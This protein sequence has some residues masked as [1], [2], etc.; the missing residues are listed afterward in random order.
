MAWLEAAKRDTFSPET[1]EVWF[2]E[3]NRLGWTEDVFRERVL[4]TVRSTTFGKV[5]FDDFIGAEKLF[6]ESEKNELVDRIIENRRQTFI[7]AGHSEDDCAEAG[8]IDVQSWWNSK[9]NRR[10]EEIANKIDEHC[11]DLRSK[12]TL[13]PFE[14][15]QVLL[16]IAIEK[17]LIV[18]DDYWVEILPLL[19]PQ[20][21]QDF[22]Q[23]MEKK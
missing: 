4:A 18:K 20:M 10:I 19:V 22:E 11:K 9:R 3:M 14:K 7:K 16:S 15:K 1:L 12:Y 6:T 2:C 8:L 5:K 17:G 23:I 21:I 13:L